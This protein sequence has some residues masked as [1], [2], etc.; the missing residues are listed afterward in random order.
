[1]K[2]RDVG[3]LRRKSS[4]K[5]RNQSVMFDTTIRDVINIVTLFI[6][7]ILDMILNLD[8]AALS[9]QFLQIGCDSLIS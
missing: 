7:S 3:V 1:M 2:D 6:K 4:S 9:Y 5:T 8:R